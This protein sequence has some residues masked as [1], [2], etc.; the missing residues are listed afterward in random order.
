MKKRIGESRSART[1]DVARTPVRESA[2]SKVV[3][4]GDHS[5]GFVTYDDLGRPRWSW[6][7]ELDPASEE[8]DAEAVRKALDTDALSLAEEPG[9]APAR[10]TGGDGGYD[11]Y[12]TVRIKVGDRF[13]R[14]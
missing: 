13:R 3:A 14:R 4:A 10:R 6:A 12:D 2:P 7:S 9:A 8:A 1:A 5:A 11:P